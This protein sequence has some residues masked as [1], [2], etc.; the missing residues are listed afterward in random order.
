MCY[1]TRNFSNNLIE[2]PKKL[3]FMNIGNGIEAP[4]RTARNL[5]IYAQ[6]GP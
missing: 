3:C 5:G 4:V 6:C 2:F 1:E